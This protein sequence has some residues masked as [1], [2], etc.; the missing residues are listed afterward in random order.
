[1]KRVYRDKKSPAFWSA[2]R[3]R[4]AAAGPR[5]IIIIIIIIADELVVKCGFGSSTA[6]HRTCLF[7]LPE[8]RPE[9]VCSRGRVVSCA[10]RLVGVPSCPAPPRSPA[11]RRLDPTRLWYVRVLESTDSYKACARILRKYGQ[12]Q[13]YCKQF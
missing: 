2:D 6:L 13:S 5:I 10:N 12:T 9:P 1:M 4:R 11:A 7:V 3:K 8:S